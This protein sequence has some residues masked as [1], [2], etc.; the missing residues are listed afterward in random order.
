MT[1]GG[2]MDNEKL[3]KLIDSVANYAQMMG[4][5][6]SAEE[7]NNH[8]KALAATKAKLLSLVALSAKGDR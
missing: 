7:R 6:K 8:R 5:A 4:Y 2:S 3:V 1:P